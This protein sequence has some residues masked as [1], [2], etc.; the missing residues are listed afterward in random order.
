MLKMEFAPRDWRGRFVN[1]PKYNLIQH[2][3]MGLI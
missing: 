2:I 1:E 3:T